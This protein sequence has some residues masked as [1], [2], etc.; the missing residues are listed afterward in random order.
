MPISKNREAWDKGPK[1]HRLQKMRAAISLLEAIEREEAFIFYVYLEYQWDVTIE[2]TIWWKSVEYIE[3][4]KNYS[5]DSKFTFNSKQILNTLCIFIDL[6]IEKKFSP[7]CIFWFYTTNQIGKEKDTMSWEIWLL[8]KTVQ[9][10]IVGNDLDKIIEKIIGF[11]NITYPNNSWNNKLLTEFKLENW[12]KFISQIDW[13]FNSPDHDELQKE[14][15]LMI[16]SSK[17][18]N[19]HH[20]WKEPII[21]SR[22]IDEL[23]KRQ[24]LSDP[25]KS[26]FHVAEIRNIFTEVSSMP[27]WLEEDPTW[28]IWDNIWTS[29]DKRNLEDKIN[30]F[31]TDF[32][33]KKLRNLAI[34]SMTSKKEE[35]FSRHKRSFLWM[36]YRIYQK[37]LD[38]FEV[39]NTKENSQSDLLKFIKELKKKI[40]T[41][42][43][44]T[45][46]I[47][48]YQYNEEDFIE[49]IILDLIDSCYLNLDNDTKK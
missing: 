46:K 44:S 13:S 21:A 14:L 15:E 7:H 5:K 3:E 48:F 24:I 38:E 47:Y 45:A 17:L 33:K 4:D 32:D 35:E 37:C 12:R 29:S 2:Q 42:L 9:S 39:F 26:M 6:W 36:K 34:K 28:K 10:Q 8:E 19:Y 49:G 43:E 16:R 27:L 41:D 40:K 18:F 22:I 25:V 30:D 11:Y 1:W 20:D 31:L 23:D